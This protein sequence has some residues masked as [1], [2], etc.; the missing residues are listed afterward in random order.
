MNEVLSRAI[1]ALTFPADDL[2]ATLVV[3]LAIVALGLLIA[4]MLFALASP[5]HRQTS[6]P[7]DFTDSDTS[8]D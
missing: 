1:H 6:E 3:V 7:S 4:F 5:R 2:Q 8:G